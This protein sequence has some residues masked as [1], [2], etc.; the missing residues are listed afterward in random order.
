M[1]QYGANRPT[2]SFGPGPLSKAVKQLLIANVGIFLLMQF[3]TSFPW[4][5]TFGLVPKAILGDFKIWQLV[6]YLFL[7]GGFWHIIMNMFALW[8]F[9]VPIERQWGYDAFMKFYFTTGIGAGVATWLF[10]FGSATPTIG[11]S[12]AVMGVLVAFAMLYPNTPI[13]L[14]FFLPVPARI[15]VIIY[16]VMEF[17]SARNFSSDGIGHIT[18]LAGMGIAFV[19][20][21]ADWRPAAAI[22]QWRRK[23]R[24]RSSR[25][26]VVRPARPARPTEGSRDAEVDAILDKISKEGI[27]SLTEAELKKLRQRSR[28]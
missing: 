23:M 16:A 22:E 27:D 2:I 3:A 20:L 19:Y 21:K 1:T 4:Y 13:L 8:M 26:K 15:F 10:T 5:Q 18:H 11:A 6:T 24:I 14:G 28:H 7:H 12:G 25:L 9:G 17:L